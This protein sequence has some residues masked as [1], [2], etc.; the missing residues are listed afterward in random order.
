MPNKQTSGKH[1]SKTQQGSEKLPAVNISS[2]GRKL[3]S[4]Q[5]THDSIAML[6]VWMICIKYYH[7]EVTSRWLD[8]I[9]SC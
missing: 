6:G 5:N 8:T 9:R 2:L 3:A 7:K 1:S 4:V